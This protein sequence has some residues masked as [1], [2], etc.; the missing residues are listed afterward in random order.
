MTVRYRS[1]CFV[2][3]KKDVRE[4]DRSFVVFTKDFGKIE[5]VGRAIRKIDSKLRAGIDEFYF[6]EIEFIQGKNFKTLVDAVAIKKIR[7]EEYQKI[8]E[9][10]DE[11]I[12]GQ[13]PD[14]DVW[15]LLAEVFNS[16]E[17]IIL[18]YYFLFNLLA[19]LG[20]QINLYDCVKCRKK[21][22]PQKNYL[23]LRD[24]G[25]ICSNCSDDSLKDKISIPPEIIKILRFLSE[26]S[27]KTVEKL[28]V[29][30]K[31]LKELSR[32][33]QMFLDYYKKQ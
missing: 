14:E 26:N 4:A 13:E 5:V 18:Y 20:Y 1:Q 16:F 12:G 33:S 7:G 24:G 28:A 29:P 30:E 2:F 9:A 17:T 8:S 6:S 31:Y 19:I 22:I 25:I 32:I 21:L 23:I 3:K 27:Y 10:A 15:N 11:L